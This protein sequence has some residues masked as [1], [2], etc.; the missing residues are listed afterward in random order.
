MRKYT[1]IDALDESLILIKTAL[2]AKQ[3]KMDAIT[4]EE[5]QAKWDALAAADA[6]PAPTE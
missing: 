1:G 4:P 6:E 2:A 5:V 3:D